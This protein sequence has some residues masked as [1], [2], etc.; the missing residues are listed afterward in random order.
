MKSLLTKS[1]NAGDLLVESQRM[2]KV[3]EVSTML[4]DL[5]H[6]Y[7]QIWGMEK[8]VSIVSEQLQVKKT[9]VQKLEKKIKKLDA[10]LRELSGKKANKALKQRAELKTSLQTAR[11]AVPT[12]VQGTLK[13]VNSRIEN[14]ADHTLSGEELVMVRSGVPLPGEWEFAGAPHA[15]NLIAIYLKERHQL[16]EAKLPRTFPEAI[17]RKMEEIMLRQKPISKY[18]RLLGSVGI[19]E[20]EY[21]ML[22]EAHIVW[23]LMRLG[24]HQDSGL[25]GRATY[26]TP[27]I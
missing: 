17:E 9:S 14:I 13:E 26:T 16:I 18:K 12:A 15:L 23:P 6:A 3:N 10:N 21:R 4:N 24:I 5:E 20:E 22:V 1:L 2:G 11:A 19:S 27:K 8:W 7:E 25:L